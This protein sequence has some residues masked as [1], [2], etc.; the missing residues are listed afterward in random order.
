MSQTTVADLR[1]LIA[2][3]TRP[4]HGREHSLRWWFWRLRHRTRAK[5]SHYTRRGDP[6]PADLRRWIAVGPTMIPP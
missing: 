3:A 6:I 2:E 4:D 5:I 1:N